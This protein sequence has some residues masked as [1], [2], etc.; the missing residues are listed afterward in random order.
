MTA[1]LS[2]TAAGRL[3]IG[4]AAERLDRTVEELGQPNRDDLPQGKNVGVDQA[5][6]VVEPA[7]SNFQPE[8]IPL[9]QEN[10]SGE[11]PPPAD[12]PGPGE[13]R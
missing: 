4:A 9:S 2:K 6:P 10:E 3:R 8:F 1:E 13:T 7:P 12:E 5:H 11:V